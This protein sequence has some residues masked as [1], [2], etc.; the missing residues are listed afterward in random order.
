[1]RLGQLARKLS[2]RPSQL[3]DFLAANNITSEEG[4]NTRLED[5]HVEMIVLHFAPESLAEIM[6]P[7][8]PEEVVSVL[9]EPAVVEIPLPEVEH[10]QEEISEVIVEESPESLPSAIDDSEVIRVQKIELAGL[11]VLGKIELPEPKKKETPVEGEATEQTQ[12]EKTDRSSKNTNKRKQQPRKS[13]Q[14]VWRNPVEVQ[15]QRELR[16]LEEKRKAEL[17]REKEKRKQHYHSKV[18]QVAQP[19]RTKPVKENPVAKKPVDKRP[20]PKTILGKFFRWWTS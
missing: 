4:S 5:N 3:V 17:E 1:M 16:E 14:R 12:G 15:R 6:K 10:I 19:K 11:K 20:A 13:E 7:S 18:K 8:M 9:E 2:L